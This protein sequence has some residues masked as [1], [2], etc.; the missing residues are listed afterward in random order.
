MLYRIII[1]KYLPS[2]VKVPTYHNNGHRITLEDLATLTSGLPNIPERMYNN[3]TYPTQQVYNF[4]SNSSLISEPGTRYNYSNLGMGLLGYVLSLKAGVSYAQLVKD[5]V[6]NVLGMDST[7]IAM[8]SPATTTPL[9]DLL[10]SRLAKGHLGGRE[11]SSLAFLPK[12]IQ[13]SGAFYSTANDM[14][15]YLAASMRLVQTKINDILQDTH[16][17][18]HEII[19]SPSSSTNVTNYVGLGWHVTT[20]HGTETIWHNGAI[21]GYSSFIGF[22]PTK[23]L[24]LVIFCSC[25]EKDVPVNVLTHFAVLDFLLHPSLQQNIIH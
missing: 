13:P 9:P 19:S 20:Y 5:R 7:G 23:Q 10:K 8:N 21:N 18:R 11:I 15:K 12:L 14:L 1:E 6:L 4:I 3:R 16:T 22:N 2:S 24:G 17:I 25:D